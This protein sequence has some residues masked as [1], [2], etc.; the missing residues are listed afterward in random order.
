MEIPKQ[1]LNALRGRLKY[2]IKLVQETLDYYNSLNNNF[3][4]KQQIEFMENDKKM[5]L[6][7]ISSLSK[8]GAISVTYGLPRLILSYHSENFYYQFFILS[9]IKYNATHEKKEN[10]LHELELKLQVYEKEMAKYIHDDFTLDV[11]HLTDLERL[12]REYLNCYVDNLDFYDAIGDSKLA[13]NEAVLDMAFYMGAHPLFFK[14]V[15]EMEEKQNVSLKPIPAVSSKTIIKE[16]EK[17]IEKKKIKEEETKKEVFISSILR[18]DQL[19]IIEETKRSNNIEATMILKD[20]FE[21]LTWIYD[22]VTD[23]E[24]NDILNLIEE[25][26]NK[27][28]IVLHPEHENVNKDIIYYKDDDINPYLLKQINDLKKGDYKQV[29]LILSKLLQH[30][31]CTDKM[32]LGNLPIKVWFKGNDYRIFYTKLE[33]KILIIGVYSKQNGFLEINKLVNSTQFKEYYKKLKISLYNYDFML[34]NANTDNIISIL[35]SSKMVRARI[36]GK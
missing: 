35:T 1:L 14:K 19:V 25:L 6:C 16:E 31:I 36:K 23:E 2:Q 33:D 4:L 34:E 17:S 7:L 11:F 9:A 13:I 5:L 27:L 30:N 20:I 22:G 21:L 8:Y 32:V 28:N 26:F 24:K 10:Y 12:Y 29:Y 18:N 15:K 3:Y